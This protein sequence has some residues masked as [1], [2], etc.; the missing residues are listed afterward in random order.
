MMQPDA[1]LEPFP[2]FRS[3]RAAKLKAL[4]GVADGGFFFTRAD[5][6][7]GE[8]LRTLGRFELSEMDDVDRSLALGHE[9]LQ[10]RRQ[11]QFR[12]GELKRNR[13]V[14]GTNCHRRPSI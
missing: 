9:A 3:I 7:A 12:I 2:D 5:V 14:L 6:D 13:A 8:V 1:M 10:G 11:R 4:Q